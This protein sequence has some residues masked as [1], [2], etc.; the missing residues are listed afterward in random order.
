MPSGAVSIVSTLLVGYGVRHT[1]HR[2]IWYIGCCIPGIIGGGL[3]S[4]LPKENKGGLLTGIY[5]V[6]FIVPTV[7][8]TYQYTAANVSGHTKRAFST[9]LVAAAFGI[10]NIIGPQTFQARDRPEYLPAK[11]TVLATQGSAAV[12]AVI[13]VTF[14]VWSNRRRARRPTDS[15]VSNWTDVTDQ[16]NKTFRYT[17]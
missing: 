11:I 13:L 6:N 15:E 12:L 5:L 2:W 14:Y 1:S 4:F 17:Y 16:D 9:S 8:I 10:G 7:M 3:M